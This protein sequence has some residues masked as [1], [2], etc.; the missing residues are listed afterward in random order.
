MIT[1]WTPDGTPTLLP[2]GSTTIVSRQPLVVMPCVSYANV[3]DR[4]ARRASLELIRAAGTFGCG[5]PYLDTA[6]VNAITYAGNVS[7]AQDRDKVANAGVDVRRGTLAPLLPSL[8]V[9][10]ECK[11]MG[12]ERLGTHEMLLGEVKRIIVRDDVSTDNPLS[13]YPWADVV[14]SDNS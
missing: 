3:N 7:F 14:D 5:V 4:Y 11:I 12:T 2:C 6:V 8:P 10:F 9:T 1:A 13:W